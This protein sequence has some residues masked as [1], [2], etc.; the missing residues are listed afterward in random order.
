M[1]LPVVMALEANWLAGCTGT[2]PL[3][4][5]SS[6]AVIPM[7]VSTKPIF[8]RGQPN[9]RSLLSQKLVIPVAIPTPARQRACLHP[10][11]RK[12]LSDFESGNAD[13]DRVQYT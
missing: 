4:S 5:R 8:G 9:G 13:K 12:G 2:W 7:V 10:S 3:G 6:P 11:A 1:G